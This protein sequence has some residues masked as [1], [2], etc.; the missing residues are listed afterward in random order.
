MINECYSYTGCLYYICTLVLPN[1][2]S[3]FIVLQS[4]VFILPYITEGVFLFYVYL[5]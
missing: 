4:H 3:I 1:I 2:T 5:A